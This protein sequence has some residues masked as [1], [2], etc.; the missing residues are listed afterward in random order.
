MATVPGKLNVAQTYIDDYRGWPVAPVHEP[1]PIRGAFMDPRPDPELGA[2][3][4]DGVDVAVRDDRPEAGAPP[5]RT[6]RVY[7]IEGGEVRR[8]TPH[9]VRGLVDIGHFRYEHVDA[10]VKVG[11]Q[12]DPGDLIGWSCFDSWHVHIGEWIF[13][14][15]D[16]PILVNPL[17]PGGKLRPYLDTA[18]PEIHEIR[19]YTPAEPAW[20][21]RPQTTVALF[22][23]A[24]TRLNKSALSGKVD[25][26]VHLDDPQSFIGFFADLPWLAAPH[27]PFRLAVA[28]VELPSGHVVLNRDVFRAERSVDT[29][30]GQHFA[31]GTDQNLPAN[32]CMAQHRTMRCD[33]IY[34]FRLFPKPYWDTTSLPNGRYQLHILA[35]DIKGNE[36]EAY[37]DVTISN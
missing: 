33:G 5:G 14:P 7:A 12:I 17:R 6:H 25:V 30:A 13:P 19:Y 32:E 16:D 31:P 34:W 18:P 11:D 24:G 4:H 26:R 22:P 8:A 20:K 29:P 21:R 2:I 9:G 36:A 35:W 28:V 23:Q 27:H 1:H 15:G 37:S 3:Y 10:L